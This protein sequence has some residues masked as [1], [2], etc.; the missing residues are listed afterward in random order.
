[1]VPVGKVL[2]D[3]GTDH[4]HL[5]LWLVGQ[6]RS[7]RAIGVE[8]RYRPY[9][10]AWANVAAAGLSHLIEIRLG[11]GL[12][13][14]SPGEAE[15]IVLAGLG[16]STIQDIL[17]ASPEIL[18]TAEI[19]ILQPQKHE[20]PLRRW[21]AGAGWRLVDEELV[22]DRGRYYL[23]LA[24]EQGEGQT[25]RPWEWEVGPLLLAKRHPLLAG[26]LDQRIERLHRVKESL[27]Q[28][29]RSEAVD[30]YR[31]IVERIKALQEVRACLP[32]AEK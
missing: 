10:K 2:A 25:F 20:V 6:G 22:L 24:W 11:W 21:L 17:S 26:Y 28:S 15:A 12:K 14:L 23:I 32:N 29:R 9:R 13:P 3:I 27:L 4:A 19:L 31:E 7:P 30:R 1:M 16:G 8:S 5:P 18:N